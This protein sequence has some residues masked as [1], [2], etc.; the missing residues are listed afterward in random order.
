[1]AE[2]AFY[3]LA[4]DIV[5]DKRRAKVARLLESIGDRVQASV[6]EAYLTPAELDKLFGKVGKLLN[7]QEDC[8]AAYM[9]C[10]GCR[11]KIRTVGRARVTPPPG[12][13]IV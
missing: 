1:M 8:L 12:L 7:A 11:G 9:L 13:R 6:F 10:E 5:A 2:R 3:V 4:Y